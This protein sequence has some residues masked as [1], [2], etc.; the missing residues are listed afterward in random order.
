[1]FTVVLGMLCNSNFQ[2]YLRAS[3]CSEGSV[4]SLTPVIFLN[5]HTI[6]PTSCLPNGRFRVSYGRSWII[7]PGMYSTHC[8]HNPLVSLSVFNNNLSLLIYGCTCVGTLGHMPRYMGR[9][10]D[11]NNKM[12]INNSSCYFAIRIVYIWIMIK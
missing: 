11:N 4:G 9:M 12:L 3:R 2:F 1:M 6:R 8:K 10:S 5:G 7:V